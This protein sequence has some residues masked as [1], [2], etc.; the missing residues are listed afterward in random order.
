M[1]TETIILLLNSIVLPLILW[2]LNE[3]VKYLKQKSK[4]EKLNYIIDLAEIITKDAVYA[5]NQTYVNELKKENKFT[6]KQHKKAFELSKDE[7]LKVL[8]RD[9]EVLLK[10]A[11]SDV[12]AFLEN[13]IEKEVVTF[14]K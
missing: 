14:K 12:N 1:K 11:V 4:N 8:G 6:L 3:A 9:G 7:I 2:G 10:Q 13:K 5:T